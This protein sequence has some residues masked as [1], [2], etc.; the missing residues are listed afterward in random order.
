MT[1]ETIGLVVALSVTLWAVIYSKHDIM[2]DS[3]K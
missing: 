3:N 2:Q 1:I